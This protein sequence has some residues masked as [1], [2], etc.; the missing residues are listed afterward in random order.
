MRALGRDIPEST[1]RRWKDMYAERYSA[2]CAAR[3]GGTSVDPHPPLLTGGRH[4]LR[5]GLIGRERLRHLFDELPQDADDVL[6]VVDL[7]QARRRE[8][9]T[10]K[11]QLHNA[12]ARIVGIVVNRT[13]VDFR[14]YRVPAPD[15]E[16]GRRVVHG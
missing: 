4:E 12:R 11:Q 9:V 3:A 14:L 7:A 1:L 6:L 5:A 15:R 10:A 2:V 8:R 16:L 13:N